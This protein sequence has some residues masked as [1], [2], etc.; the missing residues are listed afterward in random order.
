MAKHPKR[1]WSIILHHV[2]FICL[3][4][5]NYRHEDGHSHPSN[6]PGTSLI[7][8]NKGRTDEPCR[9]FNRG[10]CTYGA[11][12]KYDHRCSYCFKFGHGIL[13]CRKLSGDKD[14]TG[15]GRA[16]ARK[17]FRPIPNGVDRSDRNMSRDN[18]NN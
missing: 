4:D 15:Q 7:N 5:K 13:N 11:K 18:N 14:R 9:K 10:K 2:W 3:K 17:D 8:G 6:Q 12:C 1:N 16:D